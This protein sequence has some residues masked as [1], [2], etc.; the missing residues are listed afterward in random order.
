M[1]AGIV[2]I[3]HLIVVTKADLGAAAERARADVAGALSLATAGDEWPVKTLAIS[4][5]SGAG[6]DAL[7]EALE[8]HRVHLSADN[9]LLIARHRQSE[10]WVAESLRERFGRE[11]IA[12]LARLGFDLALPAGAQPF[13]RL[14]E[15]GAVLGEKR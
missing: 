5:R 6:I 12:R 7:T 13:L 15:L 10:G 8:S 1:K 14:R 11:G 4:S 9:R 2:E 3:P